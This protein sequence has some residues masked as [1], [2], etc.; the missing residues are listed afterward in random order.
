MIGGGAILAAGPGVAAAIG[1]AKVA[2]IDATHLMALPGL[3]NAH[4]HSNEAFERGLHG[5]VA[6]EPWL[7]RAYPPLGL[8][9]V[10]ARWHYLRVLLV[11][12]DAIHSGT[13]ALQD[14]CLNPGCDPEAIDQVMQGWADSGL[15]AAVATTFSDRQYL[16]GLPFAREEC[17]H[18]LQTCLDAITPLPIEQQAAFF[19]RTHQHWH[20]AAG[21]RLSIM[22]GPRG[23]QRCSDELLR[24]LAQLRDRHDASLHMHVLESNAQRVTSSLQPGGGFVRRLHATG[25][26]DPRMTVNHAVW[27]DASDIDH[28]ARGGACVTHNPLSNL[29][30]GSGRTPVRALLDAG[31][32]VA[33]GS[34][35]PATGDTADMLAVLRAA[36][37]IHRSPEESHTRWITPGEA[38][39]AATRSGA[40]SMRLGPDHGRLVA[41][42]PADLMLVDTRH[43]AFVPMHD[44]IAQLAWSAAPDAIDTVVV[45]GSVLMRKRRI[46][47]FD[48]DAI[49]DEAREAAAIWRRDWLPEQ[50]A[51]GARFDPLITRV[52]QRCKTTTPDRAS[53]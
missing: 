13:V 32:P 51:S 4:V 2:S 23:P 38:W 1:P 53:V 29:R 25:L 22:L 3:V 52:L 34:D 24:L 11:A 9:R 40:A 47:A 14:D 43:R 45:A 28:M 37:L 17:P 46:T 35:G 39:H 41:G 16:D 26:L 19:S 31:V 48:E 27:V 15:R 21:G 8:P 18:E 44:P 5:S 49:L 50:V 20:G 7:A 6:L 30:L 10:P 12:C 33:L 36:S 42:A